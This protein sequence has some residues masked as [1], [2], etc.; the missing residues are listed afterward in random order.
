MLASEVT[1]QRFAEWSF[2]FDRN[3]KGMYPRKMPWGEIPQDERE[4][5]LEDADRYLKMPVEQWP[6]EIQKRLVVL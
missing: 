3:Y 1:R 6:V 2:E 4:L 5:Y